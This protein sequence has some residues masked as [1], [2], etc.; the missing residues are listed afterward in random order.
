[1]RLLLAIE[2]T[3]TSGV[4]A[5]QVAARPWPDGT[6]ARVLT[7]I[8]YAAVPSEVWK[9]AD[10][11]MEFVRRAM[12]SK[13]ED[14]VARAANELTSAGL[15]AE[16]FILEGDP[17]MDIVD[18]AKEGLADFIFIRSHVFHSITRW[19]MGSV[20][21]TVLRDAPCSVEVVR[22]ASD[23][24]ELR[25]RR[26]MKILLATDGP[27]C[28]TAAGCPAAPRPWPENSEVK[29]ISATD[30]F[31]FSVEDEHV[32]VEKPI[33][34]SDTRGE[35]YLTREERAVREAKEILA[36]AGLKLTGAVVSGYPKAAIVDEAKV[37]GA[38]LIVVGAHGRRGLERLLTGS[39]S[40][41]VAMH[42]HCSVEVIRS[43]VLWE[44]N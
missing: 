3:D 41:A 9:E 29:V 31:G 40:E 27:V 16:C 24:A 43:P 8:E 7:V 4:V 33:G 28:S 17:R 15:L 14:V 30:P 21:K 35:V 25:G 44:K 12:Q 19:L 42:A 13:A 26:G 34:E 5:R 10:G 22:P 38:D 2:P 20:A 18:E 39:V 36:D 6:V 37:W 11:D 32:P 23:E 1:L